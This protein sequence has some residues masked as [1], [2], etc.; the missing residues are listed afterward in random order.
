M[1]TSTQPKGDALELCIREAERHGRGDAQ[2]GAK[3][4][5]IDALM[6]VLDHS[7]NGPVPGDARQR[8]YET[9]KAA[10]QRVTKRESLVDAAS[11]MSFPA[12]DPPSYMGGASVAGRPDNETPTETPSHKLSDPKVAG[13][14]S[15][16][17]GTGT[18]AQ[19]Q[20]RTVRKVGKD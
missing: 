12:S 10:F 18:G 1:T 5:S 2:A 11:E 8:V 13:E 17:D 6:E 3:Q 7:G 4:R 16:S 15:P 14:V 9:Y 20:G 19:T